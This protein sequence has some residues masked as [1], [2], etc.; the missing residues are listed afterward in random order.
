MSI[1]FGFPALTNRATNGGK[2]KK[3]S[4][5][6]NNSLIIRVTDIILDE[7]HPLIKN[8]TYGLDSL[9]LIIGVG[10]SPSN[11]GRTFF[12]LPSNP[13]TKK[14]PIIN[15]QVEIFQSITP[16][17]NAPQYFYQEPL[18]LYGSSSPNGNPFPSVT[19][20]ITPPSQRLDYT[21][22][23]AGAVNVVNDSSL[24]SETNNTQNPSQNNFVEKS[25]IHPLMPFEGH[26]MYEG[27]F[28]NSIRFGS[29][30]KSLSQYANSWSSVGENGDPILILRN[31]Q[32]PNT[33]SEGW[34]PI[35]EDISNDLSSIYLTSYQKLSKF[36]VASENYNSYVTPPTPPSQYVFP[37][38][39]FSSGRVV[40]NAKD[41]HILLS[42]KNSIG[43]SS[44]NGVNIDSKSHYINSPDIKLG[45][46]DA[47]ES[48]LKGDSTIEVLKQL[49][50]AI[51][52]LA[53]IL[54]V[55]KNWPGGNLQT[56][57]NVIASGVLR[58][59]EGPN[60]IISK[61][62]D[63]SLKSKTTKVK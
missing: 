62:T 37:Q 9:G 10:N 8:G 14:F 47:T 57:Y 59:L 41:D 36:K 63:E 5:G 39:A 56:N 40:I 55:E 7:N 2:P 60:G 11:L 20:N 19:Q 38:L 25:N 24:Q 44:L 17:S 54:E 30:S 61:L 27:R 28:G 52:D 29:T 51:K 43:F 48:V 32:P 49:A 6:K 3:L 21:Q 42:A 1:K 34:I 45:S 12:A 15:E 35:N 13:N 26:I 23:E 53:S 33:P 58:T 22:I 4:G 31:G 46:K 18:G 16:N 50:K